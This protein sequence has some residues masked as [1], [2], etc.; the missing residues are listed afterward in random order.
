M[1]AIA[2]SQRVLRAPGSGRAWTRDRPGS[3][4]GRGAAYIPFPSRIPPVSAL[5]PRVLRFPF[6]QIPT[7]HGQL[8]DEETRTV[9]G[10]KKEK[11]L[12]GRA[13]YKTRRPKY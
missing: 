10:V 7:R 2:F 6:P 8:P 1:E 13:L 3:R 11:K 9:G 12:P 5:G 4:T